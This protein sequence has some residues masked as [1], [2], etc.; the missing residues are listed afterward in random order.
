MREG[1]I[2]GVI[3]GVLVLLIAGASL[4]NCRSAPSDAQAA[5]DADGW[6][7]CVP[8]QTVFFKLPCGCAVIAVEFRIGFDERI[9]RRIWVLKVPSSTPNQNPPKDCAFQMEASHERGDGR[10]LPLEAVAVGSWH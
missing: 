1:L 3:L 10:T 6:A 4:T 2:A 9:E 5:E 8:G 7:P